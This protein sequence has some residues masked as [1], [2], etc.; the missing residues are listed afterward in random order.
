M[1]FLF[2]QALLSTDG[3][4]FQRVAAGAQNELDLGDT[5]PTT[6]AGLHIWAVAAAPGF[7][8][9]YASA[10]VSGVENPGRDPAVIT[11]EQIT[12]AV[13]AVGP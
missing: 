11:D 5:Q 13:V 9:A 6:W 3:D 2:D 1:S 8:D 12:A 4:F 10:V 7:A